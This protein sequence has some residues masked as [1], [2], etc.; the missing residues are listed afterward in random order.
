MKI[1]VTKRSMCQ[2]ILVCV[3]AVVLEVLVFN[4]N[5]F[6]MTYLV[7]TDTNVTYTIED[8]TLMNW[9]PVGE[10]YISKADPIMVFPDIHA[11]VHS[12]QIS[13]N[14]VPLVTNLAVFYENSET[15]PLG[16]GKVVLKNG[17]PVNGSWSVYVNARAEQLR[18]DLGDSQGTVLSDF[19]L[20]V[21]PAKFQFSI[22]R[23]VAMILIYL[24][25]AGLFALQKRPNYDVR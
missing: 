4:F 3:V 21:N 19:K 24:V 5:Y 13:G 1:A 10:N 17:A 7:K 11:N 18:I 23:F 2:F 15:K 20:I 9:E 14:T 22:S 16:T 6:Y 8:A 25:A 12:V